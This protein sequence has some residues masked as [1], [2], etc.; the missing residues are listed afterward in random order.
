MSQKN[1]FYFLLKQMLPGLIPLF[2]FIIA[3]E[4]WG[5]TVGLF[6]AIISG[7]FEFIFTYFKE[8]RIDKFI[9]LDTLLITLLGIISIVLNNDI[10]FKLKPG[11][12]GVIICIIF[13]Y[14][15]FSKTNLMSLMTKRYLKDFSISSEQDKYFK[16]TTRNLF[17][18]F[19]FYT[20]LVF[21]AAF[22]LSKEAWAFISGALFYILFGIYFLYELISAKYIRKKNNNIEWLPLVDDTGKIIG[23]ASR[24]AC[25]NDK[26]L[27][28]PV[29]HLHVINSRKKIFLQKRPET[30]D[31]QPGKWDTAVGGH[32]SFNETV[33]EA[34]LREVKEEIGIVP[35]NIRHL[36]TYKWESDV[37]SEFVFTF[38]AFL[39]NGI[40]INP[41]ELSDGRFWSINEIKENI[42]KNVFTPNFEKEFVMLKNN[43]VI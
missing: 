35:A 5:T 18:I 9:L 23:K 13:G 3:D 27:L 30:K 32:I 39:D 43:G 20:L 41:D 40:K 7:I 38:L 11:I 14:S 26:N 8:K 29:V 31:I 37:E 28:H 22:Y 4:I 24:E 25:H 36:Y 42:G 34:L 19:S 15:A 12:I 21:F 16:K 2:I 17:F 1:S 6:I 10:F 33:E